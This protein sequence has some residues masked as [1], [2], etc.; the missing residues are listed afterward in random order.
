MHLNFDS[1]AK[2][3]LNRFS[4]LGTWY[5]LALCA[6]AIVAVI[7]QLLIQTH[8]R[9]QLADSRVVNVAGKQRMLSQ[10][11]SKTVLLLRSDQPQI[12]RAQILKELTPSV[13]LWKLSQ[14]GLLHGNDSLR[15][16]GENSDA[17]NQLFNT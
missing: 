4:R 9:D 14:D 10:K 2:V 8:L 11:I 12:E 13:N 6:I 3:S 16:P 1:E 15:L 17:I 7:G 5:V